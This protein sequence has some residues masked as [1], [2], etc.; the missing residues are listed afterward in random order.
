MTA[1]SPLGEVLQQAEE[2]AGVH[3]AAHQQLGRHHRQVVARQRVGAAVCLC[4]VDT[5]SK[6]KHQ[7]TPLGVRRCTMGGDHGSGVELRLC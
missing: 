2:Q 7:L 1:F 6:A 3:G 5:R 4:D